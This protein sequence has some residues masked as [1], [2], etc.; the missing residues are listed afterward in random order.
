[1]KTWKVF[2]LTETEC[3]QKNG[4]F[5]RVKEVNGEVYGTC[6]FL[7]KDDKSVPNEAAIALALDPKALR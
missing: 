4:S 1:M 2:L 5:T 7:I 3:G 6:R